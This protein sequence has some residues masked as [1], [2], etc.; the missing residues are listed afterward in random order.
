MPEP[1]RKEKSK[2]DG[3]PEPAE[4]FVCYAT[5]P[6]GILLCKFHAAPLWWWGSKNQRDNV[7]K[8]ETIAVDPVGVLGVEGHELVEEHMAD[9]SKPHGRSWVARVCLE[10]GINLENRKQSAIETVS[11]RARR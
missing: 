6:H 10:C 1:W 4:M 5:P 7:R 2:L 8:D 3:E 9:R 11:S